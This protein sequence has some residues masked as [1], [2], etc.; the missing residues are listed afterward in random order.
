MNENFI[1]ESFLAD[2]LLNGNKGETYNVYKDEELQNLL[3]RNDV[4]KK[5]WTSYLQKIYNSV[6]SNKILEV[7]IPHKDLPLD[8][9]MSTIPLRFVTCSHLIWQRNDMT[10]EQMNAY[11][12]GIG[13]KQARKEL[14]DENVKISPENLEML[15]SLTKSKL[16]NIHFAPFYR[17]SKLKNNDIQYYID[18]FDNHEMLITA[19]ASNTNLSPTF[20]EKCFNVTYVPELIRNITPNMAKEYYPLIADL[21]F[22]SHYDIDLNYRSK[23]QMA[24]KEMLKRGGL[25]DS[26][27]VDAIHRQKAA[28][29][30]YLTES[31]NNL[32]KETRNPII[33]RNLL[34]VQQDC[35]FTALKN[36]A[37]DFSCL[38]EG[39]NH[40]FIQSSFKNFDE[41]E[42]KKYSL[43]ALMHY[44][45]TP[46]CSDN[47]RCEKYITESNYD[48]VLVKSIIMS[49]STKS[50][51]MN[52]IRKKFGVIICHLP[53]F[54]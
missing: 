50:A 25:P 9:L 4:T 20:R 17:I 7:L 44:Y 37:F 29:Y 30:A 51:L 33:L 11:L 36:P 3:N 52:T 6:H 54:I 28:M 13:S 8:T 49:P 45:G 1:S 53:L 16:T 34:K 22:D 10:K 46:K 35:R 43:R 15:C 12:G 21:A 19:L 42:R 47:E 18:K 2:T 32:A 27:I 23:L 31:F 41:F 5:E 14:M 48:S 26:C 38:A 39:D 40:W 24:F